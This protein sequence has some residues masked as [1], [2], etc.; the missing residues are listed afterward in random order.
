M[1]ILIQKDGATVIPKEVADA[2]EA[3]V[4]RDRGFGVQIVGE[5]GDV[6]EMALHV[7]DEPDPEDLLKKGK[8]KAPA[9][10]T[11]A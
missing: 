8:P 11:A 5:N 1:Q 9:P 10:G 4:Y 6:T 3:Q 7:N 2:A